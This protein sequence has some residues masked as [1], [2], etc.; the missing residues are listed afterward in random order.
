MTGGNSYPHGH[1]NQNQT[2]TE[3]ETKI[4]TETD[5][6]MTYG[7][8]DIWTYEYKTGNLM[9]QNLEY[10]HCAMYTKVKGVKRGTKD[11]RSE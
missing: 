6:R 5:G 3:S 11:G 2:D 9:P 7:H 10:V 8:M 1:Q 4:I